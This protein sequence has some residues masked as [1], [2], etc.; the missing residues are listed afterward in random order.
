M[1]VAV[2][3][4]K[5][6]PPLQNK[7]IVKSSRK[8]M[9][10]PV[11]V[12][13]PENKMVKLADEDDSITVTY[14]LKLTKERIAEDETNPQWRE[15]CWSALLAMRNLDDEVVI[16]PSA[17]L[18]DAFKEFGNTD[19]ATVNTC[20]MAEALT[21]AMLNPVYKNIINQK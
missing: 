15:A 9:A 3:M 8:K 10:T 5:P 13:A 1:P 20:I 14:T 18:N 12:P 2:L 11:L 6:N 19:S 17:H 4:C 7:M 16:R 21:Q